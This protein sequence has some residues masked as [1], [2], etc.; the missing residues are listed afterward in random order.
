[1]IVV[2]TACG[3][4]I[5]HDAWEY[6][7][8]VTRNC[9]CKVVYGSSSRKKKRGMEKFVRDFSKRFEPSRRHVLIV[10]INFHSRYAYIYFFFSKDV[11]GSVLKCKLNTCNFRVNEIS[12][13][14]R[15]I[16]NKTY[17]CF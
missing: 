13:L 11:S 2:V 6:V 9:R 17:V 15:G 4:A 1:M 12:K 8:G 7:H 5:G 3:G 16:V 14:Y 10:V